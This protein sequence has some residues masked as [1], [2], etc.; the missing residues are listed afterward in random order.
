MTNIFSTK[1]GIS[2]KVRKC[3]SYVHMEQFLQDAGIAFL[4]LMIAAA[5]GKAD[6]LIMCRHDCALDV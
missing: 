1:L 3:D 5:I 2:L 6:I 4:A